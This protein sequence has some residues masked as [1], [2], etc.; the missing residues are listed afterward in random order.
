MLTIALGVT[1]FILLKS[2]YGTI[3]EISWF[4]S[5]RWGLMFLTGL[6]QFWVLPLCP[7]WSFRYPSLPLFWFQLD[8]TLLLGFMTEV[9]L[10]KTLYAP[11]SPSW[12][13]PCMALIWVLT[14]SSLTGVEVPYLRFLGVISPPTLNLT[15]YLEATFWDVF[16]WK[17]SLLSF[18]SIMNLFW[19]NIE[20]GT[21]SVESSRIRM[22]LAWFG[23]RV[24]L[25]E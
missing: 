23:P 25:T 15:D 10:L 22:K 24:R 4:V 17:T 21:P 16:I 18:L 6:W 20:I 5:Y 2:T 19:L 1:S 3:S 13:W 12:F 9:L 8:W 7:N 11:F 14:G